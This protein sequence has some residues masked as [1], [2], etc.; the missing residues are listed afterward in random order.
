MVF[1]SYPLK[2]TLA[3]IVI[4]KHTY[5]H[6][7]T[8][9]L[10]LYQLPQTATPVINSV[11]YFLLMLCRRTPFC[12][13][14]PCPL[15]HPRNVPGSHKIECYVYFILLLEYFST[16]KGEKGVKSKRNYEH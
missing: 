12:L 1:R 10:V 9:V 13:R 8:R 16:S 11:L 14:Y 2:R 6:Y 4:T 5:C 15:Y 7:Q 3:L